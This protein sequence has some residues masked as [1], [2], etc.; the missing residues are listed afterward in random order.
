MTILIITIIFEIFN[1]KNVFCV[2]FVPS[3]L[4]E[5]STHTVVWVYFTPTRYSKCSESEAVQW[6]SEASDDDIMASDQNAAA[7][8]QTPLHILHYKW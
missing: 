5:M 2:L 8:T 3:Q 1:I 7:K 6:V 4:F